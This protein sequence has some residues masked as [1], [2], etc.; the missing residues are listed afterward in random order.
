[1]KKVTIKGIFYAVSLSILALFAIEMGLRS[2]LSLQRRVKF[3]V[4]KNDKEK[5][6][7]ILVV[8]DSRSARKSYKDGMPASYPEILSERL[9]R[10]FPGRFV[11]KNLAVDGCIDTGAILDDLGNILKRSERPDLIIAMLSF[12]NL[13]NIN[14]NKKNFS[15][16]ILSSFLKLRLGQLIFSKFKSLKNDKAAV[17]IDIKA[18]KKISDREKCNENCVDDYALRASVNYFIDHNAPYLFSLTLIK[19]LYE[20]GRVSEFFKGNELQTIISSKHWSSD[21]VNCLKNQLGVMRLNRER[22]I[23]LNK[24]LL[25]VTK[26]EA[27]ICKITAAV[28]ANV[29]RKMKKVAQAIVEKYLPIFAE[30]EEAVGAKKARA[31]EKRLFVNTIRLNWKYDKKI[32]RFLKKILPNDIGQLFITYRDEAVYYL[33]LKKFDRS[34]ELFTLAYDLLDEYPQYLQDYIQSSKYLFSYAENNN[35]PVIILAPALSNIPKVLMELET[36]HVKYT[37]LFS[38]FFNELKKA[39]Y[40]DLFEESQIGRDANEFDLGDTTRRGSMVISDVLYNKILQI[41]NKNAF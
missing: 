32:L 7:N 40:R 20:T 11:V 34:L 15:D 18:L 24:K 23:Q 5:T 29:N 22:L 37:D 38:V 36:D 10:E 16:N 2:R 31:Y 25:S 4:A 26:D 35:V 27:S 1:M 8:G 41:S 13:E 28:E 39:N 12:G 33:L 9:Q 6:F 19:D 3:S 17:D 21:K 14:V 30:N